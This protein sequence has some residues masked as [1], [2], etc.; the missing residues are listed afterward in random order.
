MRREV[1]I[2]RQDHEG[3]VS[4]GRS[5]W[6]RCEMWGQKC[7]KVRRKKLIQH[8][9]RGVGAT[10]AA[11]A[12]QLLDVYSELAERGEHLLGPLMTGTSLH[13]W[14]RFPEDD[15][16]DSAGLYQWF[17]HCHEPEDR[18]GNP[19]EHG[20]LHLFAR[21]PCWEQLARS[22]DE[23]AFHELC[24]QHGQDPQTRHLV[25]IGLDPKG[26]PISVFMVN[27]RVTGDLMLNAVWTARLLSEIALDTGY[28]TIDRM[29]ASTITLCQGEIQQLL[30]AR[31]AALATH[32]AATVLEDRALEVLAEVRL[33][34]DALIARALER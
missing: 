28:L 23:Q 11:A 27:S 15:A 18:S 6:M 10:A 17:Y 30:V 4:G 8:Q 34:M 32:A 16:I 26:V 13:Q 5:G 33:N 20:H 3:K 1:R 9:P 7:S 24:G 19:D 22:A 2:E 21:R 31:D 29:I 25:A 12:T 14:E